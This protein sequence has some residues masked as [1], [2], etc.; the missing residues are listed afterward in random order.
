LVCRVAV[1]LVTLRSC[2][3]CYLCS[4]AMVAS[5]MLWPL[6]A[7]CCDVTAERPTPPLRP[8]AVL[9]LPLPTP[10]PGPVRLTS[11]LGG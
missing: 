3:I 7:G 1:R 6:V 9:I 5:A 11:P 10:M 4:A 8:A 2:Q